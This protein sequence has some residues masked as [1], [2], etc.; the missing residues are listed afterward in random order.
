[1]GGPTSSILLKAIPTKL[2][3]NEINSIVNNISKKVE[4]SSF[5][6]K[7]TYPINGKI[8]TTNENRP[9]YIE[10]NE[11]NT[12]YSVNEISQIS[13]LLNIKP[14][15]CLHIGAMCSK[16][17]DH[18]IL[19]E[20]TLFIADKFDGIIDFGGALSPYHLLPNHLSKEDVNWSEIKPYFETMAKDIKGKIYSIN[21]KTSLDKDWVFHIC[22]V[23]FMR[24]WLKNKHFYMIK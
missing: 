19:G 6:V 24:S 12:D 8:I 22:D 23:D 13:D 21:Y 5:W 14:R 11:I 10:S 20:L 17:I 18:Q 3:W 7:S 9:F 16:T 1:M 15:Y 2:V 4:G